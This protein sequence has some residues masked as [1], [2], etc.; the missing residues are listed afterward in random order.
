MDEWEKF[1]KTTLPKKEEFYSNRNMEDITDVYYM[2][3]KRV[4]RDFEMKSFV[5]YHDFYLKSDTILLT[6]VFEN[7]RK[8]CL[9]IYPLDAVKFLSV[10]GLAWQAALKKTKVKLILLTDIDMIL[11]VEKEIRGVKCNAIN[12]Y[13]EANNKYMK[14]YDR[15]KD[16]SY[17]KYWDVNNLYGWVALQKLP[18]N[19]FEWVENVSEFDESFIK[20][21]NEE[22]HE[23]YCFQN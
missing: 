8:L 19:G 22:S 17:I 7:F 3:A 1:N 14:D 5:D 21:Y 11:M 23:E 2:H 18:V 20:S 6:D 12:R 15:K 10:L 4:C 9:E 13:A 16:S